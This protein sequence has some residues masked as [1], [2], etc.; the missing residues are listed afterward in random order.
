MKNLNE[1]TKS[2]G[3]SC[4]SISENM[5]KTIFKAGL[6]EFS[7][8]DLCLYLEAIVEIINERKEQENG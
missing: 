6:Q 3:A 7:T 5:K 2:K 4:Y 8:P 1:D